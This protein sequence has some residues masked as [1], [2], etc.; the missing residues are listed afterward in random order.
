MSR[1]ILATV[2]IGLLTMRQVASP[3]VGAEEE[4]EM[5]RLVQGNNVFAFDLYG[6][7]HEADGN[8]F[9][10]PYSISSALAMT[11]AGANCRTAEEMAKTLRL[12][13]D[14]AQSAAAF[15]SLIAA[16]NGK[17]DRRAY[18]L[19][20]ANALWG[21]QGD[22]LRPDFLKLTEQYYGAGLHQVDFRNATDAARQTINRWVEEQTSNKIKDLLRPGAVG[23]STSLVLTN[24]IYFK[25]AWMQEFW[26]K[27]TKQE[28]FHVSGANDVNVPMMHKMEECN[29]FES[30]DFQ[31]LDLPYEQR[32]LSL[33]V[34]LPKKADGLATVEK[35]LTADDLA[36]WLPKMKTYQVDIALPKFKMTAEF[37][38]KEVLSALGMP[39]A[40]SRG[41]D[42]TGISTTPPGLFIENVIHKAYVDV[43][44][45]GTEA[46]AATAVVMDR[47]S[48]PVSHP[49]AVFRADHPFVFMI[50]DNQT[51]SILF[52]GR[53]ANPNS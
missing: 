12:S 2:A 30:G 4:G 3:A 42:F 53:V 22:E 21:Q 33:L 9:F 45:K 23:P 19:Y 40:F 6:K 43:H 7:L 36:A 16:I 29:Y 1:L 14:K 13:P 39:T 8:L 28:A 50:R 5:S 37:K 34:V 38:L 41:A 18:Q 44:E 27:A 35:T 25:A 26:E 31:L 24:A 32:Q 10:S 49:K 51:G 15:Q 17:G 48:A 46:A 47:A 52:M 11:Y 20:T